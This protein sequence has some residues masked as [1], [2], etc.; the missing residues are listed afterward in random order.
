M[1][2]IY[3]QNYNLT[4]S[5]QNSAFLDCDSSLSFNMIAS[6]HQSL[7]PL[8]INKKDYFNIYHYIININYHVMS[9]KI[10]LYFY[11]SPHKLL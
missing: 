10:S 8:N 6:N 7:L 9:T 3:T 11:F 5:D 2:F 4:F 1:T